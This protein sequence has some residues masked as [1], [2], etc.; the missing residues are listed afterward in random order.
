[1][2]FNVFFVH[3]VVLI[4]FG[5]K[6]ILIVHTGTVLLDTEVDTGSVPM[7]PQ[8]EGYNLHSCMQLSHHTM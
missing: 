6:I 3:T 2:L 8:L 7:N 5:L 1:M 4:L